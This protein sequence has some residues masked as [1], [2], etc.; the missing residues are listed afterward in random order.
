M[1][2]WLRVLVYFLAVVAIVFV[3]LA[4]WD[5]LTA[6]GSVAETPEVRHVRIVRDAWGVPH[7][8]GRTDADVGYGIP[9]PTPRMISAIWRK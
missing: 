2:K 3:G 1:P 7:I 6:R 8:F 4:S 5:N 9:S